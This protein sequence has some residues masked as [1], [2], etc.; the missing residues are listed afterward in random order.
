M[1]SGMDN[2]WIDGCVTSSKLGKGFKKIVTL[3][4]VPLPTHK[5]IFRNVKMRTQVYLATIHHA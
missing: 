2:G 1:M 3:L 5:L 4:N